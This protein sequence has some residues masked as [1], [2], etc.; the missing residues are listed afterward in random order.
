MPEAAMH[1]DHFPPACKDE[2]G[3]SGKSCSVQPEAVAKAVDRLTNLMFGGAAF[4]FNAAHT[5]A[6]LFGG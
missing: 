2:V 3:F 4:G 5:L 1:E 6:A